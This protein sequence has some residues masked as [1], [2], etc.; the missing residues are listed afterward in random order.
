MG[1]LHL[2][3][4]DISMTILLE[5]AFEAEAW[6][7]NNGDKGWNFVQAFFQKRHHMQQI[8][9]RQYDYDGQEHALDGAG[10]E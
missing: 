2:R 6:N 7:E 1:S 8:G 3:K 4:Y 9:A 5:I 10:T